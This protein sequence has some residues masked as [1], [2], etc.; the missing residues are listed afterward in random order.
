MKKE[1][2][3]H[4]QDSIPSQ[5]LVVLHSVTLSMGTYGICEFLG[6]LRGCSGMALEC[7]QSKR[8]VAIA[9]VSNSRMSAQG[10]TKH[11]QEALKFSTVT[12]YYRVATVCALAHGRVPSLACP[13]GFSCVWISGSKMIILNY[14]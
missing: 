13:E 6:A 1:K 9:F 2:C 4:Q 7:A 3:A 10:Q 11:A 8:S 14:M 5:K 12:R